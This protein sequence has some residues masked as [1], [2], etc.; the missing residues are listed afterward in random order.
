MITGCAHIA[1]TDARRTFPQGR[2]LPACDNRPAA[3]QTDIAARRALSRQDPKQSANA[4][5]Q[6]CHREFKSPSL[7]QLTSHY[8]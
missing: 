6:Q 2:H 5:W 4:V 3:A 8:A 1:R 7:R